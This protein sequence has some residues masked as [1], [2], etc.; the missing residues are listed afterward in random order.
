[1]ASRVLYPPTIASSLPAFKA[2][3]N[4]L[5]IPVSFSKFND[6]NEIKSVHISIVKKDTGMNVVNTV[7]SN[8]RYRK[9]GIILN[10]P[11]LSTM[12]N[13]KIQYY[14]TISN[15]DLKSEFFGQKGWTPGWFYKV[16]IRLSEVNYAGD[17]SKQ[18]AWINQNANNFSEWSTVCIIK[19][20]GDI[21]IN[22]TNCEISYY[23][24][25]KSFTDR[26]ETFGDSLA[27]IGNY[28]CEDL[29]ETLAYYRLK[30][31]QFPKEEDSDPLEDSG[32]IYNT[33]VDL[34]E[35]NY[36]FK[37]LLQDDNI[38][39]VIEL[40]YNTLNNFSDT[41]KFTFNLM[42]IN[43]DNTNFSLLT[44]DSSADYLKDITSISQEEE[45]GRIGLKIYDPDNLT[46]SGNI[47]IRRADS[48]TNFSVWEDIKIITFKNQF[49][50]KYD[51]IYDYTAE[52]GVW[53]KYGV[54]VV[55]SESSRSKLNVTQPIMRNYEYS[56]LLGENNQQLK[57]MFNSNVSSF[58]Q[59][60]SESKTESIGGKYAIFS[61]NAALDY[62]SFSLDGLIS[63]W[64]DEQNT[65]TSKKI[66][67]GDI[68]IARLYKQ[69][70]DENEITQYDYIYE[71]EFR[72]LVS[73]FLYDGKPKLFKST[74]E[75]NIIVR[76]MD[77]SFSP[78]QSLSRML[79]SFS[80]GAY[81][82]DDNTVENYKKYNLLDTGKIENDLSVTNLKLGQYYGTVK[83]W[84]NIFDLIRKKYYQKNL[85]G[86][87]HEVVTIKNLRI[88]IEE[89]P[90]R[91][92]NNANRLV[93]GY[94]IE[95]NNQLI[96]LREYNNIYEF[97][98]EIIFTETDVLHIL[99]DSENRISNM[100]VIIDFLYEEK[101]YP[102]EPKI[103]S[104]QYTHN[105]IGQ[106]YGSFESNTDLYKIIKNKY[107]YDWDKKFS[108]L[109]VIN[110]VEIEAAPGTVIEIKDSLDKDPGDK[111]TVNATGILA[112][113][114]ISEIRKLKY[115]GV[116]DP[117]TGVIEEKENDLMITYYYVSLYGGY[118]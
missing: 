49:V 75:G 118:Q 94:N 58:K 77:V 8:G 45:E 15:D 91:V 57:L 53:Y 23:S 108:K 32:Y 99:N 93:L 115:I 24:K 104:Y 40:E 42:Q 113:N 66:V 80:C 116:R 37:T 63:F 112:L 2:S 12:V 67:Y 43:L 28:E 27:F 90:M 107:T 9:A 51:I 31:Y 14:V 97:D 95:L 71:R 79:Y 86:L 1:M 100:N 84:D 18:Q 52:S 61:R 10:V 21:T 82:L 22:A 30:L 96:T 102:Y 6:I 111:H 33:A 109:S 7:D 56:Y 65:F 85:M 64:M 103:V 70:N 26:N 29:T 41:F 83:S 55:K 110:S 87:T 92:M 98:P 20:I 88:Q 50:N 36:K 106:L 13:G 76:L 74:T 4:T 117:V 46:Y 5:K 72:K 68:D 16:Q 89:K 59:E 114:N 69:Y 73:D 39:Y 38:K 47:C 35:F 54:Q 11:I 48:R 34:N 44:A 105:G 81:E 25:A 17:G 78:D 60:K 101:S 3:S 19:A 62:K